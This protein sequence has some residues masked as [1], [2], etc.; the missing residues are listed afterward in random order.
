MSRATAKKLVDFLYVHNPFYLISAG[1]FTYGLKSLL[2]PGNAP[3]LFQ[4]GS[5]GYIEPWGL[6]A[7]L[8][9]ITLLM[10]V[11]AILIVRLGRVWEDARSLILIVLL[12]LFAMTVSMDELLNLLADKG[13]S[14]QHLV[15]ML[16]VMAS[17]SIGTVEFLLRG[18]RLRLPL[19]Y[20]IPLH[21]LLLAMIAWPALLVPEISDVTVS[22]IQ[23]RIAAF[24]IVTGMIMLSLLPAVGQGSQRIRKDDCPWTWP[25]YPWTAFLFLLLAVCLRSYSLTMSFDVLSSSGHYWDTSFGLWQLTPIFMA[26]LVILLEIGIRENKRSLK[27]FC[28]LMAPLLLPI[29]WPWLVPWCDFS[30]YRSA[31]STILADYPSPVYCTL[32]G[33]ILFYARARCKNVAGAQWGLVAMIL[34]STAIQP[35]SFRDRYQSP[36]HVDLTAW[37]LLAFATFDFAVSLRQKS[38]S[39]IFLSS[40]LITLIAHQ[41]LNTSAIVSPWATVICLHLFLIAGILI[42]T[43]YDSDFADILKAMAAPAMLLTVTMSAM[44][45][46]R[47]TGFAS[48]SAYVV[49]MTIVTMIIGRRL[50]WQAMRMVAQFMAAVCGVVSLTL[51]LRFAYQLPLPRGSRQLILGLLSFTTAVVISLWKAGLGRR[52]L[53]HRRLKQRRLKLDDKSLHKA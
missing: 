9:G 4:Q 18:L 37:P 44:T 30:G 39:K 16:G 10:S 40:V 14:L 1:L 34:L 11:T 36:L 21:L 32:I 3:I 53:L 26:A 7:W 19:S 41:H 13:N 48:T 5:V 51:G 15:L 24:P 27:T 23:K 35:E 33:L 2:R 6:M 50:D 20:R 17:F 38:A 46:A 52:W 28:M 29:A 49:S 12:M 42:S 45:V 31:T 43:I 8:A 22:Q 47:N 25:L